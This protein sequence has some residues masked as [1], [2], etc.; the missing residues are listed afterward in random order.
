MVNT[1]TQVHISL[2]VNWWAKSNP[3]TLNTVSL[4]FMQQNWTASYT[5][6]KPFHLRKMTANDF[7]TEVQG[8]SLSIVPTGQWEKRT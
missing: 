5:G 2:E 8:Y 3:L 7:H 1:I 4:V 6:A